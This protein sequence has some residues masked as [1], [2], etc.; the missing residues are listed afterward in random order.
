MVWGSPTWIKDFPYANTAQKFDFKPGQGGKYRMEF[1][2]TPFDYA[3]PEG[4][5][6]AV[7]SKL[8]EN[9][10]IGLGWINI[11]YDDVNN[12]KWNGFWSLSKYREMFALASDLPLFQLMPIEPQ[13]QPKLDARWSFKVVD[14]DRRMVAFHDDSVGKVTAWKWD[15]GDGTT[16]TEQHPIHSFKDAKS[17]VTILEVTGPDGTSKRSKVWDVQLR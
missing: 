17:V 14:M 16:S 5:E 10:L 7:E 2:I 15:F 9:A 12:P 13:F 8:R 11:D 1:Y 6:R 3:G 4:P